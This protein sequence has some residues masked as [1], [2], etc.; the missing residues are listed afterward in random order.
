MKGGGES[1]IFI[2]TYARV[3]FGVQNFE[4][5]YLFFFL[6]K[7]FFFFLGG[8]VQK[9]Y[10]FAGMKILWIFLGGHHKIGLYSWVI[11]MYLGPF[12]RSSYRMGDIFWAAK[13]LNI[14]KGA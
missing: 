5:H 9:K 6:F 2:H 7:Y 3:N 10:F 14:F 8:G 12:L 13:I 11:S 4:S 1:D